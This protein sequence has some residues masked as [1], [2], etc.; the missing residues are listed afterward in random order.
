MQKQQKIHQI[1]KSTTFV[2]D[3]M[4]YKKDDMVV[5]QRALQSLQSV[6]VALIT[7]DEEDQRH[8]NCQTS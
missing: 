1:C 7:A 2:L 8:A 5:D 6:Y 4:Y 3:M